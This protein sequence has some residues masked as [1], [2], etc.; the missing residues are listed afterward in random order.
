MPVATR[1]CEWTECESILHRLL[2]WDSPAWKLSENINL[3]H[4]FSVPKQYSSVCSFLFLSTD[5]KYF[6][7]FC[8]PFFFFFFLNVQSPNVCL[9]ILQERDVFVFIADAKHGGGETVAHC[10]HDKDPCRCSAENVQRGFQRRAHILCRN[11]PSFKT[12]AFL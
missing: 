7:I 9:R 2:I 8:G 12:V 4:F 1:L 6:S 3:Q 11:P 10:G 5:F